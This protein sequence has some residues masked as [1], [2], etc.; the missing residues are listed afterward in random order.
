MRRHR[1]LG[2]DL[3]VTGCPQSK[4]IGLVLTALVQNVSTDGVLCEDDG[5]SHV[6]VAL[7]RTNIREHV[8]VATLIS[9]CTYS[10]CYVLLIIMSVHSHLPLF[11]IQMILHAMMFKC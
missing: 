7:W 6:R 11:L 2:T 3:K 10:L 9:S 4:V 1:L 5:R 8:N